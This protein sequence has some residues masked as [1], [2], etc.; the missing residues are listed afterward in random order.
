MLKHYKPI[1]LALI[2]FCV[3][4]M[5]VSHAFSQNSS[6]S[7]TGTVTDTKGEPLIG[8]NILIEGTGT[9]TV[10]NVNG[11]FSIS[12]NT[13]KNPILVFSYLG[14]EKQKITY[15]G[16]PLKVQ[17]IESSKTLTEVVVIGYG[18]LRKKDLTGST[19][20]VGGDKLSDKPVASIAEALQGRASGVNITNSGAPGS[21]SSIHIRGLGS[22]NDCSPLLVIDG[23]PTDLGINAIN[24]NDVES[25][26]ILKDASAT[27]IY[28]SRGA[29]GVI[30]ITTKKGK[31]GNGQISLSTNVGVQEGI[32]TPKLLNS[33]QFASLHNEMM[34]NAGL[35]QR[36]DFSDPTLWEGNTT[37]WYNALTRLGNIQNYSLSYSNG[38]DKMNTYVSGGFFKQNGI[39]INTDYKRYTF[40]FNNNVKLR[41]WLKFGNNLT[42]S[43]DV[44][45]SGSYD[46]LGTIKALPTQPIYND[47]G[48]YS[49]PGDRATWYGDIRN[50]IGT[51]TINK[52]ETQGYNILGNINSEI[53]LFDKVIFKTVAGVDY[54]DWNSYSF[55]P[56]YDWKP[57]SNPYSSR[58]ETWDKSITYLLDN[59]VT[60][61]DVFNEKHNL[62][63]M[64]GSSAQN[65]VFQYIT[66]SITSFLSDDY[67]QLN[68]GLL[69]PLTG[70]G[71]SEWALLSFFGRANYN[72]AD[73]YL[74]TATIRQDGTSR[75]SS[76]NRWGTFPSFS[77]AW[78][79]TEEPFYKQ[80]DILTDGKLRF[81]YGETG[82]QSPLD[83][84]AYITRLKTA[85]YAF[86][87]TPVA[88]LY[89]LVMP[90][91]NI[92]WETVKQWNLGIDATLLKQRINVTF[93][94]YI[95]NTSDMLVGMS[96]PI[97]SGYSD[98]YTPQINAGEV[99][100]K[101]C[102][103]SI[104]SHNFKGGFEWTTDANVSFN[105]NKIISLDGDVP[106]YYGYQVH[107]V[108]KPVGAFYGYVVDGIFQT[109]DEVN[110]SAL[111]I[112]GGTS[113]GDIK[114]KD[115]DNNGVINENDRTYLGDP[116]PD[117]IF[118]MN[119]SFSYKSFDLQ[120]Y[121]QGVAGNQIYNANRISLEGMSTVTNQSI[122]VLDRWTGEGTSNTIPRAV[123][124]DPNNN[125]R[126][127]NRYIEDGSYLRLKNITFGYS[128]P[129]KFISK[130][131]ISSARLY[132]SGQNIY[133]LTKY[134]GFD[135]E[136]S[137]VDSGNYPLT[138]TFSFGL[139]IKF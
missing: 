20:T 83:T 127:S 37:D 107:A 81:G 100:N 11:D 49:G 99:Q 102:E 97:T 125:N 114:F 33:E 122:K 119:N 90:S 43:H 137:G 136:I 40:Q 70:G 94:A 60:Y 131:T 54:K 138:R 44:K 30:L 42:F 89:P 24:Q 79:F 4:F 135:P 112:S 121:L 80:N 86:G 129:K 5:C 73:K 88:T 104:T 69:D 103:L 36:P 48:T 63:V 124:A 38:N 76:N 75:L 8:V 98:I 26:D 16:Q 23:F 133:T 118:S 123:Y 115:L 35:A 65:N 77:A 1:L 109:W 71:K 117:W 87:N 17:L 113:P 19:S 108:G 68:N 78:R 34:A 91:A 59:T 74:L 46:I 53:T 132:L 64:L 92:K 126:N 67:N 55:S 14:Y 25:I 6:K 106:I 10:T 21:N 27:A 47:D 62:N 134:S 72:Y 95:K 52:N 39:V 22:I 50:P 7:I 111:Q 56:K 130:A 96:V 31:D 28:G 93:D 15:N 139:D 41:K 32:G 110:N 18:V 13:E 105:R 82:N 61:A 9:G 116:T 85:Q 57:I 29:N 58:S 120:I 128:L 45:R 2:V 51:A 66:G 84:Y 3:S 101:G 12:E